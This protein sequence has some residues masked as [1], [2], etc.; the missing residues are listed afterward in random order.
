MHRLLLFA[1]VALSSISALPAQ[2][3]AESTAIIT[4]LNKSAADWNRGDLDTFATS[5]K[6]SPDILFIGHT[7]S[8]GYAQMLAAYK[9]NYPARDKMGT[10][11]FSQVEVQP[12]DAHFATV[13]GHFHL[14]RNPAAGGNADGHYMLVVEH[15]PAGWKIIRDDTTADPAK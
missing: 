7:I 6:N 3:P 10:L 1:F 11:T 14:E 8:R 9:K 4:A 2:S 12:L 13:T 5:Y 15:T